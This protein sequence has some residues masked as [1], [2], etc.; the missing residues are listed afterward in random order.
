MIQFE[1]NFF[2]V[3]WFNHQPDESEVGSDQFTL[4]FFALEDYTHLGIEKS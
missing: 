3:G 4:I 1:D 2:Q